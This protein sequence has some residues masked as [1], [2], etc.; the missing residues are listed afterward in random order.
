LHNVFIQVRKTDATGVRF[1]EAK[2]INKSLSALGNVIYALSGATKTASEGSSGAAGGGGAGAGAAG[3]ANLS[4]SQQLN[5]I[6]SS[7]SLG[8]QQGL[9]AGVPANGAVTS[10]PAARDART[11]VPYRDSKLTRLLQNSL[12]GNAKTVII[13]TI[14]DAKKHLAETLSTL[15]FGARARQIQ[16]RAVVNKSILE[17]QAQM[18]KNYTKAVQ[19]NVK[20]QD[21]VAELQAE[22][23]HLRQ[24]HSPKRGDSSRS[25]ET[26]GP[27]EDA[28]CEVCRNFMDL[29]LR[30][31]SGGAGGRPAA[32]VRAPPQQRGEEVHSIYSSSDKPKPGSFS[33]APSGILGGASGTPSGAP[34]LY[35]DS[36]EDEYSLVE[37][38][39]RCA[40]CGLSG[41]EA[42][43]LQLYTGEMLG[44]MFSCDG[45]CGH[46]FHVRCVGKSDEAFLSALCPMMVL[47][48]FLS[49]LSSVLDT[50]DD[51]WFVCARWYRGIALYFFNAVIL[52]VG[53]VGDGGQYTLPEGEWFC[54]EC[55]S[56]YDSGGD[57][58]NARSLEGSVD[59]RGTPLNAERGSDASNWA[60]AEGSGAHS[61]DALYRSL[62]STDVRAAESLKIAPNKNPS[63]VLATIKAEYHTM[64]KERNRILAQWQQEKRIIEKYE[65]SRRLEQQ[66]RD[67]ELVNAKDTI[68]QLESIVAQGEAQSARMQKLFDIMLKELQLSTSNMTNMNTT[69]SGNSAAIRNSVDRLKWASLTVESLL[70]MPLEQVPDSRDASPDRSQVSQPGSFSRSPKGLQHSATCPNI[71]LAFEMNGAGGSANPAAGAGASA[72]AAAGIPK[73]WK[74]KPRTG[75][76][77]GAPGTVTAGGSGLA[78]TAGST[79]SSSSGSST[80][81]ARATGGGGGRS[82][83]SPRPV[84][85]EVVRPFAAVDNQGLVRQGSS[86]SPKMVTTSA[87]TSSLPSRGDRAAQQSPKRER[88][89][90]EAEIKRKHSDPSDSESDGSRSQSKFINPLKNRLKDLLKSVE[91]ETD[92][93]AEIR[94]KFKSREDERNQLRSS[95]TSEK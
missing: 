20:L 47:T 1:T 27:E 81:A 63:S 25:D 75:A 22:L 12:G 13:L 26:S 31:E 14:S 23:H 50:I 78:A 56:A 91:A 65:V 29:K 74:G 55:Y 85:V 69:N 5:R 41:E 16:T 18:K 44:E 62:S 34:G 3:G 64:R 93:F 4:A 36:T 66:K 61:T 71:S 7:A 94:Q 49:S 82:N 2:H 21:L 77:V 51:I 79:T 28:V 32:S 84:S 53:L 33:R 67:Q 80:S 40:I 45:N 37:P 95:M 42:E 60:D 8:S 57:T 9:S 88:S 17:D 68:A 52:F 43:K 59:G 83:L 15:R 24:G 58:L 76:A 6:A 89:A 48:A 92:A 73:P 39:E 90:Y 30:S 38:M 87:S 70:D 86:L 10:I 54:T 11:H 46:Q 72:G 19:E 35:P